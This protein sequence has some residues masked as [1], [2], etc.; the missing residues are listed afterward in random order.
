MQPEE[1][2]WGRPA[3]P[4]GRAPVCPP[5]S[6]TGGEKGGIAESATFAPHALRTSTPT[7]K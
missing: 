7:A 1:G 2:V 6:T 5:V 4:H 3:A